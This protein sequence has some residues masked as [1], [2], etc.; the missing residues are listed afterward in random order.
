MAGVSGQ[1]KPT[2]AVFDLGGVVIRIRVEGIF[3]HWS[4]AVGADPIELGAAVLADGRYRD[5]ER[6]EMSPEQYHRHIAGV[7]GVELGFD[8]F[9]RGWCDVFDGLYEGI[10]PLLDDLRPHLRLVA[11]TNTNELHTPVWKRLYADALARFEAV[12]VSHELGV[13][14]PEPASYR[15]ALDYLGE[16]PW[17]VVFV[18]D[19]P[20]NV[21]AAE[22]IGMPGITATDPAQVRRAFR[23]LGVDV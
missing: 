7:M 13:R 11:L 19:R 17:S 1:G 8:D 14:K 5:F 10:E 2:A 21:S 22:A 23:A 9:R 4:A 15:A 12:F 6:G 16:P 3:E 18:D 20:E